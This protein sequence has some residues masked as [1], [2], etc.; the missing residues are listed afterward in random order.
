MIHY[1]VL[2]SETASAPLHAAGL[3]KKTHTQTDKHTHRMQTEIS[4]G[5][6]MGKRRDWCRGKTDWTS[7]LSVPL[8]FVCVKHNW[9]S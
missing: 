4:K 5:Q 8:V 9:K 6:S 7:E 3:L 1:N 2:W